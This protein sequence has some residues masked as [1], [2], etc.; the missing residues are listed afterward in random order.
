MRACPLEP[1]LAPPAQDDHLLPP[2]LQAD[3]RGEPL[4]ISVD[5]RAQGAQLGSVKAADELRQW[6]KPQR[7]LIPDV[8]C[9]SCAATSDASDTP[10]ASFWRGCRRASS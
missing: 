6:S 8:G 9:V 7:I 10:R 1:K 3:R 2:H 5:I 4:M